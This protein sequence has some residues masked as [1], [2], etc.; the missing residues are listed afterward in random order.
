MTQMHTC[1]YKCGTKFASAELSAMGVP[2]GGPVKQR[3]GQGLVF[4]TYRH[5][6][7]LSAC[8][9]VETSE[10]CEVCGCLSG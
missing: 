9:Q 3:A 5:V 4:L 8:L 6:H 7:A 1:R 10:Q 2:S